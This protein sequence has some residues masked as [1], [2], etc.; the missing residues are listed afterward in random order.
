MRRNFLLV[1]A[2]LLAAASAAA[3]LNEAERAAATATARYFI[4]A[5]ITYTIANHE[6]LKLD[7]YRPAASMQPNAAPVPVVMYIHGGGWIAGTKEASAMSLQ[8]Y[9]LWGF[10]VVNVEYRLGRS[11]PAPAAVEDC[12]CALRWVWRNAKQYNFDTSKIVV[13]GGS[14]GGHLALTTGM[15]P[16][17]GE[18]DRAC[19][20]DERNTWNFGT[21]ALEPKVT[22][23]V[24][25]FGITDVAA[26]LQGPE[27]TGYA[28]SWFGA[29]HD[30]ARKNTAQSISPVNM[31]RADLPP[32]ITIHGDKDTLVPYAQ[33]QRLDAALK[34]VG[35]Q[36]QLVTIP[37]GGHGVFTPDDWVRAYT[38]IKAFL[39]SAGVMPK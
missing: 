9:L 22:A 20:G 6:E 32:I 25:W 39:Q 15:L 3:Q 30:N 5:N 13:T 2:V 12:R 23:I 8:P 16:A 36:H 38:A 29:M 18:Y 34:K 37:G 28:V 19:I 27:Q 26:M 21:P 33:A 14:A 10:A 7:L 4:N 31:A 35:A 11:S 17:N 24:N 1:A